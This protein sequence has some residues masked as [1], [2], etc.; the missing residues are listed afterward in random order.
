MKIRP[1]D[2]PPLKKKAGT[3]QNPRQP[4]NNKQTKIKTAGNRLKGNAP[5]GRRLDSLS[6]I[7]KWEKKFTKGGKGDVL[8]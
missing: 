5:A 7:K 6:R 4:G 2:N 8:V 3:R 1:D